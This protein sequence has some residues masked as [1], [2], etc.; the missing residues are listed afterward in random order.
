VDYGLLWLV[1]AVAGGATAGF[2]LDRLLQ[3]KGK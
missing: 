2:F 1:M 3:T